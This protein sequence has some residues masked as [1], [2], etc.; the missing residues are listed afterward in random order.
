LADNI[1]VK[2][3]FDGV[4]GKEIENEQY[5]TTSYMYIVYDLGDEEKKKVWF[6]TEKQQEKLV[7]QKVQPGKIYSLMK[8]K[9]PE[10]KYTKFVVTEI[11][12]A[13]PAAQTASSVSK[14]S[15]NKPV[16]EAKPSSSQDAT[17]PRANDK[18]NS[19]GPIPP[20]A[21]A[22]AIKMAVLSYDYF[23]RSHLLPPG[24]S[25]ENEIEEIA[26]K[27]LTLQQKLTGK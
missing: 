7:E 16:A 9:L 19:K 8:E 4:N 26:R 3:Q 18:N 6:A 14:Q 11:E 20:E 15:Q 12:S 22:W 13:K 24:G 10:D 25:L 17:Q 23:A 2:V 5:G 1:P 27:F 21:A